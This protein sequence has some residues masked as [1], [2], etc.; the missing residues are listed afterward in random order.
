ME[1]YKLTIEN[2]K[3]AVVILPVPGSSPLFHYA[4]ISDTNNSRYP[5]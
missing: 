1:N 5:W 4:Q 2:E 3:L